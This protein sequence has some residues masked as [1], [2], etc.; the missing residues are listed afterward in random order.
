MQR[1][2]RKPYAFLVVSFA[3]LLKPSTTAARN[4]AARAEPVQEQ[5]P[6]TAQHASDLL[7]R[8][9]A[10]A[11]HLHTPFVE[12]RARPIDRAVASRTDSKLSRSS[13]ARTARRL[14]WTRSRRRA[15]CAR[16]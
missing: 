4:L 2:D 11:H 16:V 7:H 12:E 15:R 9:E 3:L 13:I 10:R 14:C 8:L 6:V 5:R 1:D